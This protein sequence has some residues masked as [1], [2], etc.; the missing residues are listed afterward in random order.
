MNAFRWAIVALVCVACSDTEASDGTDSGTIA[1]G[2][3][4]KSPPGDVDSGT[5]DAGD[6][7][8]NLTEAEAREL[9]FRDSDWDCCWTSTCDVIC[10]VDEVATTNPEGTT[11]FCAPD[12]G[13]CPEHRRPE[14]DADAG[15]VD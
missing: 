15:T 11:F 9:W 8:A 10:D 13:Q 1:T 6:P 3:T 2:G 7:L 12:F 14:L 5:A 4:D